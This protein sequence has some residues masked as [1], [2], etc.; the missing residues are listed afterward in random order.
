MVTNQAELLGVGK[1]ADSDDPNIN[2]QSDPEVAGDEDPTRLVVESAPYFDVDKTSSYLEGDPNVLLAGERLRYIHDGEE[3]GDGGRGRRAPPRRSAGEYPVRGGQHL[4]ERDDRAGRRRRWVS[5]C[6]GIDLYAPEDP[7]PGTLRASSSQVAG[8]VA[9]IE[10]EVVV[11][12]DVADA[13][14]ISNQAFVSA[15]AASIVDQPSDDP[16]TAIVD[17]PTQ[18]VVGNFPLIFAVKTAAL[19]IDAD[20]PNIVDPG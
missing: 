9:T 11:D 5:A 1:I 17:D 10:F 7:T 18:D 4:A 14:I 13:T 12:P 8:N 15:L 19:Q 16:R 2:G 3:R 20:S 6:A